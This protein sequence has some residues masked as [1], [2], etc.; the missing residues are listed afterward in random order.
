VD[1]RAL[2]W[3][4]GVLDIGLRVYLDKSGKT[5]RARVILVGKE[6]A[7]LEAFC[8]IVGIAPMWLPKL[9]CAMEIPTREQKRVLELLAPFC[10]GQLVQS[11]LLVVNT[12]G[13][14]RREAEKQAIGQIWKEARNAAAEEA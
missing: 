3:A 13:L 12:A 14:G 9:K 1:D 5:I 7:V 8:R 10:M 6:K 2:A 4:G 11:V